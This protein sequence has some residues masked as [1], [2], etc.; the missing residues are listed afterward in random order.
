MLLQSRIYESLETWN[1]AYAMA[2]RADSLC[3]AAGDSSRL[4]HCVLQLAKVL[5]SRREFKLASD[6]LD[7]LNSFAGI[8]KIRVRA[9]CLKSKI[10]IE[11]KN[12]PEAKQEMSD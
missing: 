4:P 5:F 9:L 11:Q 10:A 2:R 1:K 6:Q 3:T 7:R 12:E 8:R